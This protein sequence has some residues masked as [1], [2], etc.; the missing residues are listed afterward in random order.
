MGVAIH[1]ALVDGEL[2]VFQ[3]QATSAAVLPMVAAW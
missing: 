3:R 1:F 2:D